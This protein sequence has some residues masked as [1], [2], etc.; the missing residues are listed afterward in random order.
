M[1]REDFIPSE[2]DKYLTWHDNFKAKMA[3]YGTSLGFT[4][5]EVT[6]L[7][8][9]NTDLHAKIPAHFA[10]KAA[11]QAA[12]NTVNTSRVTT[13]ARVRAYG[14]RAKAA[15]GYTPTIGA[16][17]G[18]IGAE[19]SE[20]LNI[21]APLLKGR[22]KGM[23]QVELQFKKGTS[24]GV[25]I[26]SKRGTET[27]FTFLARDTEPPYIDTRA[28]LDPTKSELRVYRAK[29]IKHDTEVGELSEE[30]VVSCKP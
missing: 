11:A 5:G 30:L 23:G 14:K 19:I 7:T 9:D 1:A 6:A 27:T 26:Y 10:A 8:A 16:D 29:Y 25:N 13:E 2:H 24:D 3:T 18:L 28:M 22:D 15:T 17:L 12:T 20:D 4:A 21:S